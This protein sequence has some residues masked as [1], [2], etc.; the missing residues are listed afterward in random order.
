MSTHL[1]LYRYYNIID[2]IPDAVLCIPVTLFLIIVDIQY[3]F[4]LVSGVEHSG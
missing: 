2:Y 1:T 3:H 4:I